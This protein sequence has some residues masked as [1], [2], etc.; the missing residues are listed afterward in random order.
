[1]HG[2][3]CAAHR[4]TRAILSAMLL[5]SLPIAL[6]LAQLSCDPGSSSRDIIFPPP[7]FAAPDPLTAIEVGQIIDGA[8]LA[9]DDINR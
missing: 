1:M 3:H 7:S 6:S 2:K 8:S 5:I 9:I 4:T